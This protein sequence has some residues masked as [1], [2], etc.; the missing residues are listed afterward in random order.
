MP[1]ASL[2]APELPAVQAEGPAPSEAA[3]YRLAFDGVASTAFASAQKTV[4]EYPLEARQSI[5]SLRILDAAPFVLSVEYWD[6]RVWSRITNWT[7]LNLTQQAEGWT[8]IELQR[9]IDTDRLRLTLEP[10]ASASTGLKEIE[11]WTADGADAL[12]SGVAATSQ[13][14]AATGTLPG[15][16]RSYPAPL[17]EGWI[18]TW[19]EQPTDN[20]A[21]NQFTVNLDLAPAAI[22][23]AWL[24]YELY[25]L[26]DHAAASRSINDQLAVGGYLIQKGTT[27]NVQKE[28]VNPAWLRSGDN[29]IRFTLPDNA[30]YGYKIRTLKLVVEKHTGTQ[31]L[32]ALRSTGPASAL[33]ERLF[34]GQSNTG[35]TKQPLLQALYLLD[36]SRLSALSPPLLPM[37]PWRP[38]SAGNDP[39]ASTAR[40][41]KALQISGAFS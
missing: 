20:P 31:L 28:A 38:W 5:Q 33:A 30:P 10:R 37:R 2:R 26:Q 11:F 24:V 19:P 39:P 27:W 15:Q 8:G 1:I 25:G 3:N 4:I 16:F 22:K 36:L 23:R 7:G 18:G 13:V 40:R 6:G 34:D 41:K 21:D 17:G 12:V 14:L 35:K 29:H 9:A 32:A